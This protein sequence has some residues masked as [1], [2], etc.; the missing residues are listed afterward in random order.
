MVSSKYRFGKTVVD[1]VNA[2][3]KAVE[4]KDRAKR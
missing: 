2:S 1:I 3:I 4:A